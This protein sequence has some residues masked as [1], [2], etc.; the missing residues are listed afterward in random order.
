ML[1]R[2]KI[3]IM[4][5]PDAIKEL[6][7]TNCV[8]GSLIYQN[9]KDGTLIGGDY[10]GRLGP[11]TLFINNLD[12]VKDATI[13]DLGSNAGHFPIEYIRAEAKSVTAIEGRKEFKTQ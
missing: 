6:K 3:E 2:D 7:P 9:L 1:D 13:L 11:L 12:I 5:L 8:E 4:I 10:D